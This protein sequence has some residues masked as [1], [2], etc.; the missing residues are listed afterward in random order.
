MEVGRS[1][2]YRI[3][4][5]ATREE[6]RDLS[7]HLRRSILYAECDILHTSAFA[8]ITTGLLCAA[9]HTGHSNPNSGMVS[10]L[11]AGTLISAGSV[12]VVA[13][14]AYKSI[15]N[16]KKYKSKIA[17]IRLARNLRRG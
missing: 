11:I 14:S 16:V 2:S 9:I 15:K 8:A 10:V 6:F 17:Q 12:E 4:N 7:N 5:Q 1:V 13:E 3:P